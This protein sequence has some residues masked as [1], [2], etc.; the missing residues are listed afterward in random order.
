M[1]GAGYTAVVDP[2]GLIAA[3]GFHRTHH[4]VDGKPW[5]GVMTV[6]VNGQWR[7]WNVDSWS[8]MTELCARGFTVRVERWSVELWVK[9]A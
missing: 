6:M 2:D 5:E 8:T 3:T 9:G 4:S 7:S 1:R